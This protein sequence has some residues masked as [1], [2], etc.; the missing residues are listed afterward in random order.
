MG[1]E[2]L[3]GAA[4]AVIGVAVVAVGGYTLIGNPSSADSGAAAVAPGPSRTPT[5]AV[6]TSPRPSPRTSTPASPVTGAATA[7]GTT[8]TAAS[9]VASSTAAPATTTSAAPTPT[10]PAPAP[11]TPVQAPLVVLNNTTTTGLAG[12]AAER[13]RAAGWTVTSVGNLRNSILSTCA[14][15]DPDVPGAQDAAATLKAQFPGIKRVEPKF[16]QLPAGP[17]VVVLTPDWS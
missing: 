10:S 6:T 5:A 3:L 7:A 13:F 8:S 1:R 12:R 17:V 14:Y 16:A 11:P 2:Q 15:Y 9:A 4:V